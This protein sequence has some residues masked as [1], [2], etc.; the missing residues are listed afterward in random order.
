MESS[1]LPRFSLFA[2]DLANA[3]ELLCHVL[4]GCDNL[5][6]GVGNLPCQTDPCAWEAHGEIPVP[7]RLKAS[8]NHRQIN[9]FLVV[10]GLAVLLRQRGDGSGLIRWQFV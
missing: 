5:I 9:S 2:D 6:E 10:P 3:L 4:V 1:S 8:Q 7:H